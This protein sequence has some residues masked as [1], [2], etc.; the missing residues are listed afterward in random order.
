MLTATEF[1]VSQTVSIDTRRLG[2]VP[3]IEVV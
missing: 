1:H 2:D 3:P